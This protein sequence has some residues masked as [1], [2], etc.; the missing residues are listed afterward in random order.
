MFDAYHPA[1]IK[2]VDGEIDLSEMWTSKIKII[3]SNS[4]LSITKSLVA[5]FLGKTMSV[6]ELTK[7]M[8]E[9][10]LDDLIFEEI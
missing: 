6:L 8:T 4:T 1:V 5:P 10:Q 3:G 2:F 9:R 7:N